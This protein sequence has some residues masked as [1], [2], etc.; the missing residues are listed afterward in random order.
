[1]EELKLQNVESQ[2]V[3][4]KLKCVV[5]RRDRGGRIQREENQLDGQ[6]KGG[7]HCCQTEAPH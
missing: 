2:L 6:R 4:T 5:I 1:M 7:C 3:D